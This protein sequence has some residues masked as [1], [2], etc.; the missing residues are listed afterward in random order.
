[1]AEGG[2]V[3]CLDT[4]IDEELD[5]PAQILEEYQKSGDLELRNRLVM[6]YSYIAKAVAMQMRGIT[7]S[8]AQTEDIVNQGI[9]TLI[10]CLDKY[11]AGKG[12]KFESYAF[13]RIKCANI[14]FIRKQDWLP[15]R[16]R[17]AA[18]D[19]TV[20]HEALSNQLMREPTVKEIANYMG[21][22]EGVVNK[23][24]SEITNSVMLSFEMLLQS[25]QP[26][27]EYSKGQ[28]TEEGQPESRLMKE[29]LRSQLIESIDSLT[30]RERLVISLYYKEHLKFYEIA[31]I[32][33]VSESRICQTHS[34]AILKLRRKL[35]SYMKG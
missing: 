33:G 3:V 27:S 22:T 30:E 13:M 5:N 14:D 8:Y 4:K 31:Q 9:L 15:R 26:S 34:K 18:R 29:E 20:A 16:V 17:K 2:K 1:M 35:Q 32:M 24:Y 6:H 7:A 11:R 23:H 25:A 19:I 12:V 10:D 28:F 21:V